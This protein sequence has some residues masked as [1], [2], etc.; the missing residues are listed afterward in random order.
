MSK[1]LNKVRFSGHNS[2][3]LMDPSTADLDDYFKGLRREHDQNKPHRDA[4][5]LFLMYVSCYGG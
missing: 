1:Q 4:K 3:V 5:S 2:D